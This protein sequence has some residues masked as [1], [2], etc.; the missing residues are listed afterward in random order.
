MPA[1][2]FHV[3]AVTLS[4]GDDLQLVECHGFPTVSSLGDKA[5]RAAVGLRSK[6]AM[7]L[8]DAEAVPAASLHRRM[9]GKDERVEQITF[10]L[11][12]A[13]KRA[14]W[15][16][17]VELRFDYITWAESDDLHLAFVPVLGVQVIAAK[18]EQIAARVEAHVRLTLVDRVKQVSLKRLA[19]SQCV[20]ALRVDELDVTANIQTPRELEEAKEGE[21]KTKSVLREVAQK[22]TRHNTTPGFALEATLHLMRE[23]LKARQPASVLLIGPPG[24]GK[25]AAV[26]ELAR[27]A[28]SNIWS[29]SGSMLIAG[30]SG[31]GQWQEQCR[32]LCREAAKTKA[33]LHLGNLVEL[34]EVGQH[35]ANAQSIASFLRPWIARG[36][37][38]AI[39]ECT[40]EQ[41]AIIERRDP[42]I[43]SAFMHVR[44]QEPAPAVTRQ[45]LERVFHHLARKDS[46]HAL[47]APA[48]D[49]LHRLHRRYATYSANPGRPIR[50]LT[51]LVTEQ[52]A[53]QKTHLTLE[54]VT[55]A[56]TRETGLP[57]VLLKDELPLDLDATRIWFTQ[58]VIGQPEAVEAM[59]DLLA[60]IKARLNRPKQPLGSFLFVGPTGTGKTELAKSLAEFLFGSANRLARFD[61]SEFSDSI[62]VQRLIGGTGQAEGLLTARIREQ[63]FSVLLF[64]EFEK[65]D[66]AFFDLLLQILGDGRLTDAAGRA[67]DFCNTVII[68]TSNLGAREFQR[69]AM[70]FATG[71]EQDGGGHFAEAVRQFLRPEIYNRLGA[72]LRF[73]ALSLDLMLRVTR[74]H[75]DL[76]RQRDGIRLRDVDLRLGPGVEEHLA[77]RGHDP[78][79]GARPLKRILERTLMV[80]LA[81]ALNEVRHR[82]PL[83]AAVNLVRNE[84]VIDV[85]QRQAGE[86]AAATQRA[87]KLADA[88]LEL[89]RRLSKLA[90]SS[91]V[92]ALENE[93][94]LLAM[95]E[96]RSA[97]RSWLSPEEQSRLAR[98]GHLRRVLAELSA[99]TQDMDALE[100]ETLG[101]FHLAGGF[102]AA[103]LQSSLAEIQNQRVKLQHDLFRFSFSQPDDIVVAVYSEHRDW[104]QQ[105][106][107]LYLEHASALGGKLVGFEF[108]LPPAG[109]DLAESK[110]RREPPKKPAEPM[111]KP[112]GGWVGAIMHLRGDL[113]HPRFMNET[114]LHKHL[115]KGVQRL[116]L[117]EAGGI[118]LAEYVPPAGIHRAG[119]ITDKAIKP[120]RIFNAD[121]Q[122][123]S[124]N[125]IGDIEWTRSGM[126]AAMRRL[127]ESRLERAVEEMP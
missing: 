29:T 61:L 25:T 83:V 21:K 108:V 4:L 126:E 39:A 85:K 59:L 123:V 15:K 98:L 65:A 111:A 93:V 3:H 81:E 20:K 95:L 121:E 52:P 74:R 17:P 5:G 33:V 27:S 2:T 82:Q 58:R 79:Y 66:P 105:I 116:C 53:D 102:D 41:L 45:I 115:S 60:T 62:S 9:T 40:P 46:D 31:F 42:H 71:E 36:E 26:R 22:L 37:L 107:S 34:M 6:V 112:P 64:D 49:W 90:R 87:L 12:P 113:F 75:L 97:K 114:G 1:Q 57:E 23:S 103:A 100:T 118:N 96:R 35:S 30:Q 19:L 84:L 32:E 89:R 56:F 125:V 72:I 16:E 10:T 119:M 99:L 70:G 67:A 91:T 76:L 55:A 69:G 80:P 50:F 68:M 43:A 13:K 51:T 63:P 24:V 94:P 47:S 106:I 73:H 77:A 88:V 110:P 54:Q 18:P 109:G 120:R 44:V 11:E 8:G 14:D 101:T 28:D 104:M 7:L 78:K 86:D 38:L 117:V 124:D 127:I 48:L 122:K 92:S